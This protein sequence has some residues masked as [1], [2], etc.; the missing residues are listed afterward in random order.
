MAAV[1]ATLQLAQELIRRRSTTPADDGCQA[2][3]GERLKGCGFELEPMRFG[4]VDNLWA[5]RGR[6]SP[7]LVFA[8]HT[9]VVPTG[10]LEAWTSDPFTPQLRDGFLYGRGAADMKGSL[11]AMV[12]AAEE[13]ARSHP[14]HKG[15]IAFLITSDEE[16]IATDGTRRVV[17][18]LQARGEHI[19]YCVVGEPSSQKTLGDTIKHGRRGSLTGRLTVL[20]RQGH[21]A[22]P[23]LANNPI[24]RL[25]PALA[26]LCATEWDQGNENF[27]P[28]SFQ[29]SNLNAGTGAD[30]VIPGSAELLFNLRYSTA[31][32][33]EAIQQLVEDVLDRHGLDYRLDWRHSGAPFLTP[34]GRLIETAIEAIGEVTGMMPQLS[35][36]GGTS[37]GRFIAPM[38]AQV[39]ELGP[40]NASIHQVNEHVRVE[41]LDRLCQIYRSIL[42]RLLA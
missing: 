13:F 17:E 9:D 30:N 24:H 36:A 2:L 11:A 14:Q 5:R 33:A 29:V 37:D 7:L 20:G 28:T 19:D 18:V 26:E 27:P 15:S 3:V 32:T 10:P 6:Q 23:H 1:T 21:V 39:V 41:D 38:G 25:A 42:D 22:Y 16:G 8:G 40:V 35:T 12:V 4:A 31:L 34:R